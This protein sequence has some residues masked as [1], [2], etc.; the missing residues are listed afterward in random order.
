VIE[1]AAAPDYALIDL[2]ALPA[3]T[4]TPLT[5]RPS[6]RVAIIQ[7]P[8]GRPKQIA[9]GDMRDA[10]DAR[11]IAN[12]VDTDVGSSGAG[13]LTESGALLGVHTD[14]EC[15]ADGSGANLGW[16]AAAI[17]AVSSYLQPADLVDR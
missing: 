10:C 1:R 15:A 12:D 11:M 13:V 4:P 5:T 16:T 3:V 14:G 9:V 6:A 17:L 7:H 2:D 8:R